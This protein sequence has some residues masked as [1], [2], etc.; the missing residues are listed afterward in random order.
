MSFQP[1][2]QQYFEVKTMPQTIN[3]CSLLLSLVVATTNASPGD[4]VGASSQID[5][6]IRLNLREHNLQPNQLVSDVQF[7][8]RVYLDVIGRIPTDK[9]LESFFADSR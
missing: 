7:I 6:I 1:N 3:F 8:R 4:L 5:A 9:E 2:T